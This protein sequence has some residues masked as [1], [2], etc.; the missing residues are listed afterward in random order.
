VAKAIDAT[1]IDLN[2]TRPYDAFASTP[3]GA[4]WFV[5]DSFRFNRVLEQVDAFISVP[6]MKCHWSC[7]VTHSLKNLIGLVP[8]RFYRL[9]EKDNYRSA[10]HGMQ[11]EMGTRLPRVIA[12]LNRARPIHLALIDGIKTTEGG[13]GPWI[14]G[15]SPVQ[16]GVL[17]AG[18]DP[19]ATDAV[20]TAA[21]GYDP[22][23]SRDQGPFLRS[24][25]H[26]NVAHELGLGTNR[27]AEIE[28]VGE[29]IDDVRYD[30]SPAKG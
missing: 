9:S 4:G 5:Y 3:V 11:E 7:G 28:V 18:K 19:V 16:P 30:F 21:M 14:E 1:L 22:A 24:D 20:A 10:F 23:A 17:I 29:T 6:K 12:D 8:A 13:E 25:N 26:L 2:D 27:L 15:L